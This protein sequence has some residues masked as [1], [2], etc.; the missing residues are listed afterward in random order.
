M[1]S[2][3]SS[4]PTRRSRED[5]P[6]SS[7]SPPGFISASH[8]HAQE[9]DPQEKGRTETV[10]GQVLEPLPRSPRTE[11]RAREAAIWDK[12]EEGTGEQ[13]ARPVTPPAQAV[14]LP[15]RLPPSPRVARRAAEEQGQ[16]RP[17][18]DTG[19]GLGSGDDFDVAVHALKSVMKSGGMRVASAVLIRSP[20]GYH[21]LFSAS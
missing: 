15:V 18:G 16:A 21:L 4:S 14:A 5:I 10:N 2:S 9:R 1:A 19:L 20:L 8:E 13:S 3:S 7:L 6:T 17:V 12:P 11:R